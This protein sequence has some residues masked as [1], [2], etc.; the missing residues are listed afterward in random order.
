VVEAGPLKRV[1]TM[2]VI[3]GTRALVVLAVVGTLVYRVVQRR[4]V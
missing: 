1:L 2:L 4:R 3:L